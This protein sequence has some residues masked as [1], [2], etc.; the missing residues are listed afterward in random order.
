MVVN[1]RPLYELGC[2][3]GWGRFSNL[4]GRRT[5]IVALAILRGSSAC[6]LAVHHPRELGKESGE[7]ELFAKQKASSKTTKVNLSGAGVPGV[8]AFGR[9]RAEAF[10]ELFEVVG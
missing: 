6:I 3:L 7:I 1:R 9:G 8:T 2:G 4:V 10:A 5:P